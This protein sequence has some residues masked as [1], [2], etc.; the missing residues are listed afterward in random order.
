MDKLFVYHVLKNK[1]AISHKK[2]YKIFI[3]LKRNNLRIKFNKKNRLI[4]FLFFI[5]SF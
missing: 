5:H 2:K 4:V 1:I 3:Y